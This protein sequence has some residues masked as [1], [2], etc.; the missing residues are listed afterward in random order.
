M[1]SLTLSIALGDAGCAFEHQN[2]NDQHE[3]VSHLFSRLVPAG[4]LREMQQ[5]DISFM[6]NLVRAMLPLVM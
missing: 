1:T 6:T 5:I 4:T 3:K 2:Q